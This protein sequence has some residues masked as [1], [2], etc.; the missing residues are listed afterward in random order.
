MFPSHDR[1]A[2]AATGFGQSVGDV[3]TGMGNAIAAEGM[4]RANFNQGTTGQFL[5]LGGMLGGMAMSDEREKTNIE[6][7]SDEDLQELR[8]SIKAYKF[9]YKDKKNGVGDWIGV[10]AQD[11]ENSKIGRELVETG[12]D[13][14][15]RINMKK[16]GS[17]F[18]ATM[19]KGA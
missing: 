6:E 5:D 13:G 7:V 9:N 3:Y 19:A 8:E 11:L 18:L 12:E 14:K 15:K 10:M 4:N 2:G 16:V 17:L 1:R